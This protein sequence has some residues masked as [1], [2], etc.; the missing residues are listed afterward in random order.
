MARKDGRLGNFIIFVENLPKKHVLR[1]NLYRT[2]RNPAHEDRQRH[3]PA[4]RKPPLGKQLS[5]QRLLFP[6][7]FDLPVL[8]R[9]QRP[10]AGRR[11][12]RR[13][14][15]GGPL[16][17]RLYGR[18]HHLDRPAAHAARHG[19]RGRRPR[20]IPHVGTRG[21]SAQSHCPGAP[22]PLPPAL[23]RGDET[24][25]R[26]AAR[27]TPRA[28]ARLQVGRPDAGRG[29]DAREEEPRGD[30]SPGARLPYRIRHAYAGHEDV[31]PGNRRDRRS[32]RGHRQGA[33]PG[34]I[35]PLDRLPARRNAP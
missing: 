31:P 33:G 29:R 35:V 26:G 25:A 17:R 8:L 32:H 3:H 12:R 24:P 23:P 16:R 10:G 22:H 20:S 13:F 14:G 28:A 5:Q 18:G 21:A 15:R 6:A 9:T 27:N 7:G 30:R 11:D 1:K 4:A 34:R 2:A 19:R